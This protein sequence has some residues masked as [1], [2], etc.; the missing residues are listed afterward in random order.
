MAK[1]ARFKFTGFL[2]RTVVL[3][4]DDAVTILRAEST[5]TDRV[6]R[7]YYD[8][9]GFVFAW[10][11]DRIVALLLAF[12]AL[13]AGILITIFFSAVQNNMWGA[14]IGGCFCVLFVVIATRIARE[15]TRNIAIYRAGAIHRVQGAMSDKQNRLF[16]DALQARI[17]AAQ[18]AATVP[19]A[20]SEAA[21]APEASASESGAA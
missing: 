2:G 5:L 3:L 11:Q 17:N 18:A 16:L 19:P 20:I 1:F 6:L 8:Q 7:I 15:K 9:V 14:I 21:P 10:N 13:L 12:A 4:S